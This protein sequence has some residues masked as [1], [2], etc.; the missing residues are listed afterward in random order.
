[1]SENDNL[2]N[3][4][5]KR[6]VDN[7]EETTKSW[8]LEIAEEEQPLSKETETKKTFVDN[9]G[10]VEKSDVE[11]SMDEPEKVASSTTE[12]KEVSDKASLEEIARKEKDHVDE[13]DEANAE[14]AEDA[15]N[16]DRHALETK[17]FHAMSL[18]QLADEL[19]SLLKN[20]K[21]QTIKSHVDEIK[22]E[23]NAKFSE[24]LE[25]KKEDFLTDG[26]NEIDFYFSSP[27]KKRF[28]SLYNDYRKNLNNYYKTLESN[29]KT[30]LENRLQ[31]IEE[32]KGLINVEEN[33]NTTY[34]HFK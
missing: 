29:L 12:D 6:E 32:I 24:I 23:F 27:I 8:E 26:G 34:K 33:I 17:D 11:S 30:N 5:G 25:E 15:D 1:M 28:N 22:S 18:D 20:K 14:D 21:V 4:D 13:I 31:I 19:E 2:Q 10:T 3:A 9:D 7:S 16:V